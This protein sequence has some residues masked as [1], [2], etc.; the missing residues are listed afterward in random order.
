MLNIINHHEKTN[1]NYNEMPLH[2]NKNSYD[3]KDIASAKKAVEKLE[4]SHTACTRN[5]NAEVSL[6]KG[7]VV[8]QLNRVT[9]HWPSKSTHRHVY[10]RAMKTYVHT[11]VYRQTFIVV[12]FITAPQGEKNP[13]MINGYI[14]EGYPYNGIL[15]VN[16]KKWSTDKCLEDMLSERSQLQLD[17]IYMKCHKQANLQKQNVD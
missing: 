8:P 14:K 12:L 7:L 5:V 13:N 10:S 6:V 17:Y 9:Y 3:Q 1:Q 11:N 15:F 16:K 2:T 4:R